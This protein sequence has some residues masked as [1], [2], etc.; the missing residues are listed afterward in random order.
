MSG[1]EDFQEGNA[2]MSSMGPLPSSTT[3]SVGL[4]A[5]G[6]VAAVGTM[7]YLYANKAKGS[8]KIEPIVDLNNQT[9]EIKEGGRISR[10]IAEGE[11]A[12]YVYA[13][14]QTLHQSFRR[15]ARVSETGECLGFRPIGP[16]GKAGDYE[17][18][19]Y[20]Q[21]ICRAENF[22][23][24]LSVKG[25]PK[26]QEAFVGIYSQNR[27]EWIIAEQGCYCHARVN[28][29][30]YDTLGAEAVVFIINKME[31]GAI[32]VDVPKKAVNLLKYKK[33]CPSLRLIV[34]MEPVSAELLEQAT[35]AGVEM[36]EMRT[37]EEEGSRVVAEH[38]EKPPSPSDIATVCFTSGTTGTPKGVILTHGNI[39]AD[40]TALCVFKYATI[41]HNDVI[42]SFLPLAHMFE[43]AMEHACY[44][45][46][47]RIGFFRGDIKVLTEDIKALRPTILPVVPRLLNRIY[48][49][50]M[51]EAAKSG[52]KKR[53]IDWAIASK[54]ASLNKC[55]VRNDTIWDAVVFK[56]IRE[57]MGGRLKVMVSG[58][59][60]LAENVLTFIRAAVGCMV[61][62]G[63][64]QTEAVAAVT[65]TVEGDHVPGQV[66][67]PLP[68]CSV[69]LVD[70]PDMNY[71]AKD[72]Q[73]E[74]CIRG[75]N[76]SQGY[77]KEPEKTAD[78][79][80]ADGWLHTGD[81]GAWTPAGQLKIIDRKKHIFKL[82][83]GEYVAPEK[84]ENIY[85][86]SKY[87]A[88]AFVHGDSLKACLVGV[89][90]PDFEVLAPIA[91]KDFGL[92]DEVAIAGDAR[93]KK[94]ILEDMSK[95]G[96]AAGLAS[97]EQ[98]KDVHVHP[99][100]FSVENGLL[101]PTFKSKRPDIRARFQD[102]FDRMYA[103]LI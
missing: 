63:Y 57:A 37:L 40:T 91:E 82:A 65:L 33:D 47:A 44:T 80:D 69:K 61:L 34:C 101:T 97:F 79:F 30:L 78:T 43:R 68:C 22:A 72:G 20:Q 88:Q 11:L 64:G 67:I 74:V 23:A 59:A 2:G 27:P 36:L 99:E 89:V 32:V 4:A 54:T 85:T 52:L 28:V 98:V 6:G 5:A 19:S 90:V 24:G 102:D 92:K 51:G 39:I 96:K 56:K 103:N 14:A 13:D 10:A 75:Y 26:G 45:A 100:L 81:I 86:S 62:E 50:V 94:L 42:M 41:S 71:Y 95:V 15:G 58:S 70:V 18:I 9:R 83:Q 84:I 76:V 93:V 25:I 31:M 87:I 8:L 55:V 21:A 38:P 48:D 49:K 77:Y 60:P 66:G 53:L 29:P 46:G 1:R 3:W 35:A 73:G 12:R 17:W 7:A 16:D